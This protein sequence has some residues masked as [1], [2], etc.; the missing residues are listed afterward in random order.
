MLGAVSRVAS[1]IA[2]YRH[3]S[4]QCTC[5]GSVSLATAGARAGNHPGALKSNSGCRPGPSE[6]RTQHQLTDQGAL[7]QAAQVSVR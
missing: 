5:P 6:V 7:D 1:R 3:V 2:M 4:Y